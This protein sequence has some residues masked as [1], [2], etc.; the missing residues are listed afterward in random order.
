MA[1]ITSVVLR[2]P[3]FIAAT[4]YPGV[5]KVVCYRDTWHFRL[6]GKTWPGAQELAMTTLASPSVICAGNDMNPG[7]LVYVNTANLS[8]NSGHPFVVF[9][10][11]DANPMPTLTWLGYQ[12][13]FA[14]L[15]NKTV[16][17]P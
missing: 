11:P 2:E 17:W 10:A 16:L 9:V 6:A 12:H 7:N 4:P 3:L 15:Q 14:N 5:Q 8:P 1:T 13:N